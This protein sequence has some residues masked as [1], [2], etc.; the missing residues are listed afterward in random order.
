M[1]SKRYV[2]V[3]VL[4]ALMILMP[5]LSGCW[6]T[7]PEGHRGIMTVWGE[8]KEVLPPGG[9]WYNPWGRDVIIMN[10]QTKRIEHSTEAA[11]SDLQTVGTTVTLN[12]RIDPAKVLEFYSE[13][14]YEQEVDN[15]DRS[16]V[17]TIIK[18]RISE[19]LKAVT[20][21][22]KAEEIVTKR[23]ELKDEVDAQIRERLDSYYL[24][25][26]PN[27]ISLTDF[28]FSEEYDRAIEKKQV[29][30]QEAQEA[31]YRLKETE[32][33]ARERIVDAES[34]AEAN[35]KI[36]ESLTPELVKLQI[37][38]AYTDKWDGK[39]P[40]FYGSSGALMDISSMIN[41]DVDE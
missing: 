1:R 33:R 28:S 17:R 38:K 31:E 35:R 14:G 9:H 32:V 15:S 37:V 7:V 18:P 34:E 27:G 25:V 13:H 36:A 22:Y 26:S 12:Y 2:S 24:I 21:Q 16:Y 29:A 11:S 4:I 10:C 3:A 39:L 40:T 23:S 41:Q 8:A 19:V 30:E 20:A 6:S 5:M